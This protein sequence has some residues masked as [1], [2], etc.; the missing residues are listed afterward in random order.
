[1]SEDR[2]RLDKWLY[3]IRLFKTRTLAADRISGGGIRVNGQSCSKPSRLV[4]AGD[5]VTISASGRSWALEVVAPGIRRGP[6]TE[7]RTLYRDLSDDPAPL[8]LE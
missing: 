6:A 5:H 3:H 7:A 1:M 8:V 4:G 2:I